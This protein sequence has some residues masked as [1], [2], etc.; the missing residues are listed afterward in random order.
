MALESSAHFLAIAEY[1]FVPGYVSPCVLSS[2][3]DATVDRILLLG[4]LAGFSFLIV[5]V[6]LCPKRFVTFGTKAGGVWLEGR[7]KPQ[8]LT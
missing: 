4:L 2:P 3:W 8:R 6:L 5:R 1:R 7:L